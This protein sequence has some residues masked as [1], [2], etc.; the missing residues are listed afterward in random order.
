MTRGHDACIGRIQTLRLAG[1]VWRARTYGS[2]EV[3]SH[4]SRL[5]AFPFTDDAVD[6]PVEGK[7]RGIP[8]AMPNEA[9]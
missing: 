5:R 6:E 4:G 7:E 9:R 2:H 8:N 3:L 1:N